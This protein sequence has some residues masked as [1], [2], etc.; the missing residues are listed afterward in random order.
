[1]PTSKA[2]PAGGLSLQSENPAASALQKQ[3]AAS[4]SARGVQNRLGLTALVH[5]VSEPSSQMLCSLQAFWD[6]KSPFSRSQ[7]KPARSAAEKTTPPGPHGEVSQESLLSGLRDRERNSRGKPCCMQN[8]E[9]ETYCCITQIS[10]VEIGCSVKRQLPVST[11]KSR[12]R[13]G[14]KPGKPQC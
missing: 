14:K 2:K 11:G 1:M 6:H 9:L 12:P 4:R 8:K 10:T 13:T 3:H 5:L 7:A